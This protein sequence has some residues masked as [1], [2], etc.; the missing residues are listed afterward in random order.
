MDKLLSYQIPHTYQ[1]YESLLVTNCVLDASETGV[2]KTYIA[3]A[4][5]GLLNLKP[6]IICPKSVINSWISVAKTLKVEIFGVSNYEKIKGCKYYNSNL[7][8]LECPFIDKTQNQKGKEEF[9]FQLPHDT[10]IIV[11]EAHR[12]KNHK[13]V[14]SK[15]LVSMRE[16]GRKILLLSATITDKL[17]CF[18]PF[19]VIFGLYDDP[20]KFKIWLKNKMKSKKIEIELLNKK[21]GKKLTD[22]EIAL[23]IIHDSIFPKNGS[24]IK[25]K[26]LG[27]MFPQNQVVAECYYSDEHEKVDELYNLINKAIDDLK[28]KETRSHALG[29]IVRCRMRIEMIKLPIILDLIDDALIT[30]YSTV[31]FVNFKDSMNYLAHHLKEECSLI[32]GDQSLAERQMSI[33]DFQKN[34]TKIMICIIQAGG[35]GISLHDLNGRPRMSIISP[36]W[37]GTDI[38]QALGRIH[39]AGSKS[40]ALQR[41]VYIAKSYEEEICKTLGSKLST[42]SLINDDDLVGPKIKTTSLKADGELDVINYNVVNI[43]SSS[44]S[45]DEIIKNKKPDKLIKKKKFVKIDTKD[46]LEKSTTRSP[47][48]SDDETE[49][50]GELPQKYK[51]KK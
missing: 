29:E 2:G 24:R 16:S 8:I 7:E 14:N 17:D 28:E 19:G 48:L 12:C 40:P 44:D 38:V 41:I 50:H 42:L 5:C 1:L 10:I 21:N 43:N 32:H 37:S 25:I 6:F 11:D 13:T 51:L 46:D 47:H 36:S 3:L 4:C 39:R 34:K 33:D 49:P 27:D 45:D 18:R 31:I 20:K 23:K 9:L 35:V 22:T 15:L 30:G 26:E